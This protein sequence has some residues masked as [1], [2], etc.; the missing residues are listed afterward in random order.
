[1]IQMPLQFKFR[2]EKAFRNLL[3]VSTPCTVARVRS[4]IFEQARLSEADTELSM[5]NAATGDVLAPAALLEKDAEVKIIV[6]RTPI[7]AGAQKSSS[8]ALALVATDPG[9]GTKKPEDDSE[10]DRVIEQH[11]PILLGMQ[12]TATNQL[13]KYT[14]S[15]RLAVAAKQRSK[16]GYE[17]IGEKPNE[18]LEDIGEPPPP[19][20]TCHRCGMTGG[21]EESHWIWECPTNDDPN[22]M[23]KV[24]TAKGVPRQFLRKVSLEE[25]QKLS[26]GGVTFQLPGYSGHYIFDHEASYEEKKLRL[27]ETVQEKVLAAFTPGAK[28]VEEALTCPLCHR[29]FREAILVPCCGAT[30]CNDCIMD[31]LAYT[32]GQINGCP[33]CKTQVFAHMLVNNEDIRTLVDKVTR[34]TAATALALENEKK[35]KKEQEESQ[36]MRDRSKRARTE[37]SAPQFHPDWQPFGFGPLLSRAEFELWRRR[38]RA[39]ISQK[40]KA[41]LEGWQ[42][43]QL[44]AAAK[45]PPPPGPPPRE[46]AEE[47]APPARPTSPAD[48]AAVLEP[49]PGAFH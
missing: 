16:E 21:K 2:G 48:G 31:H 5:E 19:N 37:A 26:A 36:A 33:E 44:L 9:S 38:V 11:D 7:Q 43:R 42:R 28:K 3:S 30:Y 46:A 24:R 13:A 49:P 40:A 25:G 29:L 34:S 8:S 20:Y 15:Y 47:A 45:A 14:R 18:E 32:N 35:R 6:K 41:Q 27:G 1:M 39:G 10:L 22:H 4:A 12:A 17:A 23:K